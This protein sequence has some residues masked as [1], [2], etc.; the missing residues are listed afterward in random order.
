[1]AEMALV[2]V[3][4]PGSPLLLIR[5]IRGQP[6]D[7]MIAPFLRKTLVFTSPPVNHDYYLACSLEKSVF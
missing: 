7:V 4:P 5:P 1:M 3:L 6:G 2:A